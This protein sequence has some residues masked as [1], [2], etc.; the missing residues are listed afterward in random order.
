MKSIILGAFIL[1]IFF[2]VAQS[3]NV[4]QHHSRFQSREKSNVNTTVSD[5][6]GA[7]EYVNTKTI[8]SKPTATATS[9]AAKT[10]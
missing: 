4:S 10:P 3:I 2:A 1:S 8:E 5:S 6:L 7:T 9:V